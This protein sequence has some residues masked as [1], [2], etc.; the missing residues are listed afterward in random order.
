MGFA[1]VAEKA[2]VDRFVFFLAA[3]LWIL[4][5][6]VAGTVLGALLAGR[7]EPEVI[8]A[9]RFSGV[10]FLALLLL[11]VVG[12]TSMGHAPWIVSALTAMAAGQALPLSLGFLA[13]V[14]AGSGIIWFGISAGADQ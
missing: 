11:L 3:G 9:L 8:A 6:W 14:A 10:L 1:T 13:G 4:A 5:L 12:N 7:M 2:P